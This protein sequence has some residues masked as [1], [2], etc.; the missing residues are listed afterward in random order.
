MFG[1]ASGQ[2]WDPRQQMDPLDGPVYE[3]LE[4]CEGHELH[5]DQ[6]SH[7]G[8]VPAYEEECKDHRGDA[9]VWCTPPVSYTHL[10]LPTSDG[11]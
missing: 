6:C 11:V 5:I 8:F 2:T 3:R 1:Y 9:G 10:T 4:D 7:D